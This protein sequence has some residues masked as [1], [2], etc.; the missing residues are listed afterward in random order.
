MFFFCVCGSFKHSVKV[1][2][3]QFPVM[4]NAAVIGVFSDAEIRC[5]A[6]ENSILVVVIQTM[7]MFVHKMPH[8]LDTVEVLLVSSQVSVDY[9]ISVPFISSFIS[10]SFLPLFHTSVKVHWFY[11]QMNV[12]LKYETRSIN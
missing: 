3:S 12:E 1:P 8:M 9:F 6:C 7:K 2:G 10:P 5:S 4:L 11:S